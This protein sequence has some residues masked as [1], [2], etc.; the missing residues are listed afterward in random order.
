MKRKKSKESLCEIQDTRSKQIFKFWEFH[1]EKAWQR[2]RKPANEIIAENFTSLARD[3]DIQI[4]KAQISP[5]RFN[6]IRF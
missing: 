3:K 5:N 6:L 1:K 4:Q 2:Y